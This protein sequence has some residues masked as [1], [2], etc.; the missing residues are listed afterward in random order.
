MD[1][2]HHSESDE[3]SAQRRRPIGDAPV[4][5]LPPGKYPARLPLEGARVLLEPIA[6]PCHVDALF[7]VSHADEGALALWTYM[8]YGPFA[9]HNAMA[10]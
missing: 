4:A 2:N 10:T 1:P 9:N 6:P 7:E 3:E 5:S 8:P